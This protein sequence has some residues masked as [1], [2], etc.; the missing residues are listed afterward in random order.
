[1]YVERLGSTNNPLNT[2]PTSISTSRRP[3]TNTKL[4]VVEF[5]RLLLKTRLD[6]TCHV[7]APPSQ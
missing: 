3:A 2:R 6:T 7:D 4:D 5:P 1:M